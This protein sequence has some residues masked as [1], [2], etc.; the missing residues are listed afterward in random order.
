MNVSRRKM[1][2]LVGGGAVLAAG[3]AFGFAATRTPQTAYLP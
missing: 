1:I 3:G 2:F